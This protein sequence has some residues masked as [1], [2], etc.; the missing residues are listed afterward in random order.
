MR[1]PWQS[2]PRPPCYAPGDTRVGELVRLIDVALDALAEEVRTPAEIL[3]NTAAVLRRMRAEALAGKLAQ[4]PPGTGIGLSRGLSECCFDQE[5]LWSYL[6]SLERH[7]ESMGDPREG[8]GLPAR[9]T[10]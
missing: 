3:E 10:S 4:H 5:P 2:A 6:V 7:I 9:R 1:W 8:R